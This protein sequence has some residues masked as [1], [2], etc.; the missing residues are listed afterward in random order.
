MKNNHVCLAALVLAAFWGGGCVQH[1]TDGRLIV[2]VEPLTGAEAC[3]NRKGQNVLSRFQ[4][5]HE[6][7]IEVE[8]PSSRF[9]ISAIGESIILRSA[10]GR[11]RQMRVDLIAG[12][13]RDLDIE[14]DIG[15]FESNSAVIWR[16]MRR[17][18]EYRLGILLIEADGLVAVCA[19]SGGITSVH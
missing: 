3:F 14:I 2:P 6:Q 12:S 10:E 13:G 17:D 7:S 9:D 15:F 11:I 19:G 1:V 16:E 4:T 5:H 8:T 18:E